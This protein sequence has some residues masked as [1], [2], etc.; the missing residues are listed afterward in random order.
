MKMSRVI[1]FN[2]KDNAIYTLLIK[3]Q[4]AIFLERRHDII[5]FLTDDTLVPER[6]DIYHDG[7]LYEHVE[8][9]VFLQSG[10]NGSTAHK[11][12]FDYV[13][14]HGRIISLYFNCKRS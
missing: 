3:T 11:Y 8:G 7:F 12:S 6:R 4:R 13:I 14:S 1:Y 2:N 5:A 9:F 10:L